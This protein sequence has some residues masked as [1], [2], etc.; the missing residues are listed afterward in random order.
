MSNNVKKRKID[1]TSEDSDVLSLHDGSSSIGEEDFSGLFNDEVAEEINKEIAQEQLVFKSSRLDEDYEQVD[2][3]DM[4]SASV[5]ENDFVVVI[6]TYD[7]GS[8]KE[9][10][11]RFNGKV[12]KKHNGKM[13]LKYMR[14]YKGS[15]HIFVFPDVDDIEED[16]DSSRLLRVLKPESE[17]RGRYFF[18][19][20][21]KD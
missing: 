10:R 6:I 8:K 18:N 15:N 9:S 17:V 12:I 21:L 13:T 5:N 4:P 2:F 3:E 20:N 1:E 14:Q 19:V 11:E 7:S 16:V